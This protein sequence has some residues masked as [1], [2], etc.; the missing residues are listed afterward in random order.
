MGMADNLKSIVTHQKEVLSE[1]ET[2]CR[3]LE[4]NDLVTEN[5]LLKAE[6]EKF[7]TDFKLLSSNAAMLADEN[8]GLKNALYE[9]VYNEKIKLINT[10]ENKLNIFFRSD[11]GGEL[12][13]LTAIENR[14][15]A[16]I[17]GIR[18]IL[19]L[20]NVA[21]ADDIYTKL[22]ALSDLVNSKVTEARANA[23]RV[24]GA[25]S[26]EE[27]DELDALKREQL[28]DEQI[29]A[30]AKKNNL[31]RFV[32][33]NVLNVVGILLLIVGAITLARFTYG[34]L[35]A[36]LK[37][38]MLFALGGVMLT[39]G[40][41]LNRKKPNVFS[42]G[43]SAGGIGILY[44]ALA[45]SYFGLKILDMYPAIIVCVLITVV[46]FALSKR[47]DSQTIAT[48]ALIGG[49]LPMFS[50]GSE[51][52]IVYGAM[53]YFI[54]LNL[55]ALLISFSKKWRVSA[56]VGLSLNILG[57]LYIFMGLFTTTD[58]LTRVITVLYVLFA[59][60]IYSAIPIVSTYRT[61]SKFR[62]SDIVLLAINTLCS[63]LI[64]YGVFFCF[65]WQDFNGLL[66][67]IFAVTY[68][69][70]GRFVERK[71]A[72]ERHTGALFY[73]TGLA[74]VILI[75]P[76]QFGRSW[77]SLGWLIEGVLLATYGILYDQKRF[78][79]VGFAIGALCL[80]AFIL[81]DRPSWEHHLFVYKY[82]AITLGSLIILSAYMY[83][84]MMAGKFASAYK[85]FVMGN[86]W[87]FTMY[88]IL[89]KLDSF[90]YATYGE[91]EIYQLDY[92][93]GSA[94]I[95]AT[96][97]LA[98]SFVRIKLLHDLGT[99]VL[100]I[101]LYTAGILW[102][103]LLNADTAPVDPVYL[104]AATPA[105]GITII[106]TAIIFVLGILS[107]LALRDILKMVVVEGTVGVEWYPLIISGYFV[108]ILTQ[109][110]VVQFDLS[111]SN[112]A[113]SIIYVL[114]ALAWIIF[115]F[116]RRYSHIRKFGL[117]L[118]IFSVI[119]LFL[120]DLHS[121]TQGAQIIS[122]FALGITLLAISYVYQ[123]FSKRLEL[124]VAVAV[125]APADANNNV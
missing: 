39:A 123:Y 74:F 82:L 111:F 122:Y 58:T 17:R 61:K 116:A 55:F 19:A 42:L 4:T 15:K 47:Y 20:N 30:V 9:Q 38:I 50:I 53:V 102:L 64:M 104:N 69:F 89:V 12:N 120:I 34:Q 26:Q 25:F 63:S 106:G 96:F 117:V 118:A 109:S 85:Y 41:I 83:K 103:A 32:G 72:D 101:M 52:A 73:L 65:R 14:V 2:E 80:G 114:T 97:A 36:L 1:L 60:L 28:T 68:L 75:I 88:L 78:K 24:S 44:T 56:F 21:T 66:A 59:F 3:N 92:L 40:E 70:L 79:Q 100:S 13:K 90:L 5:A 8:T 110:L 115:G 57:T 125:E 45:A 23:A 46:A 6:L 112:V 95:V 81:V 119:K 113:I 105:L 124:K 29:R 54:V 11:M 51:I 27:R 94:A 84:R 87:L 67:V 49:Y 18:D 62:K 86:L 48:F 31:E 22:D 93:L 33:L 37:G 10:V 43:V 77:L 76:L 7:R 108:L 16:R 98:Y 35:P 71:F 91:N 107:V 121:L 99:R